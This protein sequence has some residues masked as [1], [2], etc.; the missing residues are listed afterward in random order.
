M[1][2]D[3]LS[4]ASWFCELVLGGG[5]RPPGFVNWY[6]EEEEEEEEEG[7]LRMGG[8]PGRAE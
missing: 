2:L 4:K 6:S 3:V 1:N 5:G 8:E 7:L